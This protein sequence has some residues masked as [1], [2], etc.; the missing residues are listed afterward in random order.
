MQ[1]ASS[2]PV[3]GSCVNYCRYESDVILCTL[4][5]RLVDKL[6]AIIAN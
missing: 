5:L 6:A 1:S 2:Q 4:I 3:D